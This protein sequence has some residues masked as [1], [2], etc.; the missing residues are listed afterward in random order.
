MTMH[1]VDW[2]TVFLT[3]SSRVLLRSLIQSGIDHSIWIYYRI[4]SCKKNTSVL[5]GQCC[6]TR[7]VIRHYRKLW[8]YSLPSNLNATVSNISS[9][10]HGIDKLWLLTYYAIVTSYR[11]MEP[12]HSLT[13]YV[14]ASSA[15][16]HYLNKCY[17][18]EYWSLEY[19]LNETLLEIHKFSYNKMHLKGR[20]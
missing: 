1:K 2:H 6:T 10:R 15:S 4:F 20:M 9:I 8:W 7:D 16:G 17:S 11:L 13:W 3:T 14:V 5:F 18:T 19:K 12:D